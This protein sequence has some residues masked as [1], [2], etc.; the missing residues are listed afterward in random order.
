[1]LWSFLSQ[2]ET[3][4]DRES[5]YNVLVKI[6]GL[7]HGEDLSTRFKGLHINRVN[8]F[9]QKKSVSSSNSR[10]NI[11]PKNRLKK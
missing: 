10:V 2:G 4:I 3:K 1:M 8:A 6:I 7:E 5:F 9:A 11:Q